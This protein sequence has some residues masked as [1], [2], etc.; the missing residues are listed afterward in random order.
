VYERIRN[1]WY[2]SWAWNNRTYGPRLLEITE[3][4]GHYYTLF[5]EVKTGTS[6]EHGRYV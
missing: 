3:D 6:I 4:Y 1:T 2:G 5:S